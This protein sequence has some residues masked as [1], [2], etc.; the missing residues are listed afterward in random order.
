MTKVIRIIIVPFTL[1][2]I[3]FFII[4][5]KKI[6]I[7]SSHFKKKNLRVRNFTFVEFWKKSVICRIS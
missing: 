2:W 6:A 3:F 7:Y 1:V 4:I 5:Y